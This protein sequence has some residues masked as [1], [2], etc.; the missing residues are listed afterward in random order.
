M[1]VRWK[2]LMILSGLFLVVALVGVVTITVAMMPRSAQGLLKVRAGRP[3]GRPV[4]GR[5]DLLQAGAPDRP[6]RR[7]IHEDFAGLYREW[8][9]HAE[10]DKRAA[11]RIEWLVHLGKAVTLDKAV[12]GPRRDLLNDAMEQDLPADATYWAKEML[13]VAADEPDAHYVLA[14]A[15]LEERSPNMPE[16][17][18]HLDMLE[19]GNAPE[20]RRLWIRARMADLAKDESG[21]GAALE[22]ARDAGKVERAGCPQ[23][24]H[25]APVDSDGNPVSGRMAGAR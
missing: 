5:R 2:P 7:A 22:Q 16:V 15:T 10:A 20:V 8:A 19:K 25:P 4:P 18:Q 17:K 21:A 11:L 9:R 6:A 13:N 14:A 23:P 24:I 12:K 1:T 3:R